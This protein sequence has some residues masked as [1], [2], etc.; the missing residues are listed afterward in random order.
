MLNIKQSLIALS[1]LTT[2]SSI[3]FADETAEL[4][5]FAAQRF[6]VDYS[7]QKDEAKT[8]I[9]KQYTQ[10]KELADALLT[11]GTLKNDTDFLVAQKGLVVEIWAQKFIKDANVSEADVKGL[12]EK[13]QPQTVPSYKLDNI[14]VKTE[15]EATSIL[16]NIEKGK[17]Q[18]IRL[19][20]FKEIA[21]KDSI[22]M[23]TRA[24][25]G[26]IDWIEINKVSPQIQTAL[27]D[28]TINDI[29]KVEMP[30]VGWQILYVENIKAAHKASF[31]ESK[32]QLTMLAKQQ[33]LEAEVKKIIEVK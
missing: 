26:E 18:A 5:A 22:D 19:A 20:K 33:L 29:I 3:T 21:K 9:T 12:Y 16:K 1:L 17:T 30:N 24:K 27:K 32:G 14:L 31:E 13:F 6:H 7:A 4:Q 25:G 10:M 8:E 23:Q 28:K 11:K 15:K 2:L